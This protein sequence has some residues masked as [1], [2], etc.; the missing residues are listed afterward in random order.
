MEWFG[1]N[2]ETLTQLII[3]HLFWAEL[4]VFFT[5]FS[6]SLAI[7][8]MVMP[9]AILMPIIGFFI[10]SSLI[11]WRLTLLVVTA[12]AL[13]G[14]FISYFLGRKLQNR[15]DNLWPFTRWPQLLVQGRKFFDLH[16]GKGIIICRF[17]GPMRAIVPMTVG[18]CNFPLWRFSLAA[19][20][21]A[22]AWAIVYMLPGILFGALAV[23]LPAKLLGKLLLEALIVL[24][25]LWIS[26]YGIKFG[27]LFLAAKLRQLIFKF[28]T[29]L[30]SSSLKRCLIFLGNKELKT[31]VPGLDSLKSLITLLSLGLC[32]I[33]LILQI[34]RGGVIIEISRNIYYLISSIRIDWLDKILVGFTVLGNWLLVALWSLGI[35]IV[36]A[37]EKAKHTLKCWCLLVTAAG[38]S[39]VILKWLIAASRPEGI[40]Y[41][42]TS[43]AFPS[44][45][46][47][48]SVAIYG[49]FALILM[50]YAKKSSERTWL[51]GGVMVLVALMIFSR[52]YLGAHWLID[53]IGGLIVGM[54]VLIVGKLLYQ[55]QHR[56]QINLRHL[57]ISA[58]VL[59]VILWGKI[60]WID[61][62]Q[63]AANYRLNWP[64]TKLT[65]T[66]LTSSKTSLLPIYRYDRLGKPIEA[67]NFI[68][69]GDL[70]ALEQHLSEKAWKKRPN[71]LGWGGIVKKMLP[72]TVENHLPW[73]PQ[74]YHNLGTVLLMTKEADEVGCLLMLRL[75]PSNIQLIDH[76]YPVWVGNVELHRVEP[77]IFHFTTRNIPHHFIGATKIVDD[78]LSDAF[79]VVEKSYQITYQPTDRDRLIWDGEVIVAIKNSRR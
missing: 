20:P 28:Y 11:S 38:G 72:N 43:S 10:G 55:T 26:W 66:A 1:L 44:S 16:G 21:A 70:A 68:Y 24:I 42:A 47:L 57:K 18:A 53:I 79:R 78:D 22:V 37:L 31:A 30:S 77:M 41:S 50:Q 51:K 4:A 63:H 35:A 56:D 8:G 14:D 19:V 6:E 61:H 5:G 48:L 25:V 54:I 67:I 29:K 3:N 74:L 52:L 33:Y 17:I 9:G 76:T 69:V 46:V 2:V 27:Y 71:N 32:L 34:N 65:L 75:W 13:T 59:A 60:G 58:I 64:E 36:L 15:I 62:A 40:A 39:A 45:H 23:E 49:F 7:L 12:G 73:L